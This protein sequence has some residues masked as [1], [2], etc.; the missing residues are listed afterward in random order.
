VLVGVG[1]VPNV[2]LAQKTGLAVDNGILVDASL[3]VSDPQVFAAGDV[4]NAEHPLIKARLLREHWVFWL[5]ASRVAAGM[6]VYV[7][8]V[9][10]AVQGLIRG[11]EAVDPGRL[12]DESIP[13]DEV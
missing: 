1:A 7:W 9:N 8:H 10:H 5:N 11:G 13:L 3:T 4:A 2:E 6:N 12:A